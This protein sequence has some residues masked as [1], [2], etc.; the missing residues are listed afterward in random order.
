MQDRVLVYSLAP[1]ERRWNAVESRGTAALGAEPP[2]VPAP[3]SEFGCACAQPC[4]RVMHAC[5][6]LARLEDA[7]RF[8]QIPPRTGD[9]LSWPQPID[10]PTWHQQTYMPEHPAPR[11]S[12]GQTR[13]DVI[14]ATCS[15]CVRSARLTACM[16]TLEARDQLRL[17][18]LPLQ[19]FDLNKGIDRENIFK[20]AREGT[21]AAPW[22]HNARVLF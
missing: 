22:S 12:G 7:A 10:H 1:L 15:A 17:L 14:E 8:E 4:A 21:F 11:G 3:D 6:H 20:T 2:S 16:R 13:L 9:W 18:L 5:M 19:H